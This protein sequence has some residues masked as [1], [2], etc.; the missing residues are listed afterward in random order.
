[1][2]DRLIKKSD[3]VNGVKSDPHYREVREYCSDDFHIRFFFITRAHND[4]VSHYI[5]KMLH[6]SFEPHIVMFNSTVWDVCRYHAPFD[7]SLFEENV[8]KVCN[9][10]KCFADC[11]LIW[12]HQPPVSAKCGSRIVEPHHR[13]EL[14]ANV[15]QWVNEAVNVAHEI[16]KA[17]GFLSIDLYHLMEHRKSKWLG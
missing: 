10:L 7:T 6:D 17:H 16:T 12:L 3:I 4:I 13:N 11:K 2:N 15:I 14:G 9:D 1:M 8:T 5:R